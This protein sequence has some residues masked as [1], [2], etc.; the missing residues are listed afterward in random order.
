MGLPRSAFL[1][2]S[3]NPTIKAQTAR[4][5]RMLTVG[6]LANREE[7]GLV[8]YNAI[9]EHDH[10]NQLGT[11][12]PLARAPTRSALVLAAVDRTTE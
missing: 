9:G 6:G 3:T 8:V 1:P 10:L 2:E 4:R 12:F 5:N 11:T 7:M